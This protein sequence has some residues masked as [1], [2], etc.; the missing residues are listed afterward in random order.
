MAFA[1][2]E[3]RMSP[4]A[5]ARILN[6]MCCISIIGCAFSVALA[7]F[8]YPWVNDVYA[9]AGPRT[10][11]VLV[12]LFIGQAGALEALTILNARI[13]A[14]FCFEGIM[15]PGALGGSTSSSAFIPPVIPQKSRERIVK[16]PVDGCATIWSDA[17]IAV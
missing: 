11:I 6:F 9:M 3:D 16:I 14:S 12:V 17:A 1:F 2:N 4:P 7:F 5:T 8:G 10:A 15:G 13:R